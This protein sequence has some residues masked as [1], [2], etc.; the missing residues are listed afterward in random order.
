M[1]RVLR[2]L[3]AAALLAVVAAGC[4]GSAPPQKLVLPGVPRALASD[5]ERQASEIASAAAARNSCNALQLANALRSDVIARKHELPR[6][7][8]APLITGVNN[9]AE[10]ITCVP[11]VQ[12]PPKKPPK[13]PHEHHG[14]HGPGQGQG[15]GQS[16][17]QGD[18]ND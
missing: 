9:L 15:Q 2:I 3:S 12:T 14:R 16:Q 17:G 18:G 13:P 1:A 8:R 4:A 10:R 11:T 7:L 5:W 6:R